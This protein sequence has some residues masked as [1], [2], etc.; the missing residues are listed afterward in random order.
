MNLEEKK[1]VKFDR[2]LF[3]TWNLEIT[4][5]VLIKGRKN[6]NERSGPPVV[7]LTYCQMLHKL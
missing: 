7:F 3:L 4:L 1:K 6:M 5:L 2:F